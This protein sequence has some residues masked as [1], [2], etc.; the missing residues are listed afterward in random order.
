MFGNKTYFNLIRL[1]K[2]KRHFEFALFS[3]LILINETNFFFNY[4]SRNV[5]ENKKYSNIAG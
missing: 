2:D 4:Q 5:K 3:D 1:K